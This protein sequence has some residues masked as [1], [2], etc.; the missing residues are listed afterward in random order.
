ML[1]RSKTAI[2]VR[3]Q[4]V[5]KVHKNH[6]I[7]AF[8]KIS[9]MIKQSLLRSAGSIVHSSTKLR[10]LPKNIH[11]NH[12][13]HNCEESEDDREALQKLILGT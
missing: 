10:Q 12:K 1:L 8:Q 4:I 11:T 7:K 5:F 9:K 3:F 6:L 13:K 2:F